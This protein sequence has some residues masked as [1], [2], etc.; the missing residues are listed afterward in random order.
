MKR[1]EIEKAI[2][3]EKRAERQETLDERRQKKMQEEAV[4]SRLRSHI[5]ATYA[6]QHASQN[7]KLEVICYLRR[8]R[9][10]GRRCR[11]ISLADNFTASLQLDLWS[12]RMWLKMISTR[13]PNLPTSSIGV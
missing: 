2:Y 1:K 3:K 6:Q 7:L 11:L 9:W 13:M 12:N 8:I 10:L 5:D 4:R